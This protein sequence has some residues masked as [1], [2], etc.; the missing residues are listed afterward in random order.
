VPLNL[1]VRRIEGIAVVDCGGRLTFGEEAD[2][3]RR[4][5]LDL[6]NETKQI[7]LN[8]AW[9]AHIDSSGLGTLV[10]SFISARHRGAEIKLAAL[11]PI[12]QRALTSTHVD[13]LFDIYESTEEAMES[14]GPHPKAARG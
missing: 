7:V 4:L 11:S 12:T 13:Q 10:A 2:E 14:F 3:F 8:F 9:V 6:L 1:E 5:L